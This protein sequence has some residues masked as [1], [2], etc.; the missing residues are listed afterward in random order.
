MAWVL[1]GSLVLIIEHFS[2]PSEE[3]HTCPHPILNLSWPGLLS[4]PS[5][6]SLKQEE[7]VS[8]VVKSKDFRIRWTWIQIDLGQVTEL[9]VFCFLPVQ[10]AHELGSCDAQVSRGKVTHSGTSVSVPALQMAPTK[11]C[12]QLWEYHSRQD[13]LQLYVTFCGTNIPMKENIVN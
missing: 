11:P 9:S 1:S 10:W 4:I 12:S 2:G 3:N 7:V 8:S 5:C 13:W 6:P